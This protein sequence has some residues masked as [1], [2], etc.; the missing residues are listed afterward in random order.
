MYKGE[1]KLLL[2]KI[3]KIDNKIGFMAVV[4][5]KIDMLSKILIKFNCQPII[6]IDDIDRCTHD[7]AVQVLNAVKL[8]LSGTSKFYT[9]L[10]IDPRLVV[11]AIESSYKETIVKA[12]ITGY[13]FIDKIVQI[14]FVLPKQDIFSKRF[15]IKGIFE[16]I[17]ES[18]K[19]KKNNNS[20]TTIDIK[21]LTTK[22]NEEEKISD[23]EKENNIQFQKIMNNEIDEETT[24]LGNFTSDVKPKLPPGAKF[25][26]N[27]ST[28][29]NY[30]EDDEI[31][32]DQTNVE[33]KELSDDEDSS[34]DEEK[35]KIKENQNIDYNENSVVT[36]KDLIDIE[37]IKIF[38]DKYAKYL[39][40]NGRRLVRI[41]NVYILSRKIYNDLNQNIYKNPDVFD[42]II[43]CIIISE[44]WPYRTSFLLLFLDIKIASLYENEK[45]TF[46]TIKE[47]YDN[48]KKYLF[49]NKNL[50]N[51]SYNDSRD[52]L[53]NYMID[54]F[55]DFRS[56]EF[57]KIHRKYIFNLNPAITEEILREIHKEELKGFV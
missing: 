48:V 52:D 21:E 39:D 43:F 54:K 14:P 34:D 42:K 4:R 32:K 5:E 26:T 23:E 49:K 36:P 37:E 30:Y 47:A 18:L 55:A 10:A 35:N 1:S 8:L 9:F 6:F 12:G 50:I 24:I 51:L 41:I 2:E 46:I 45:L 33:N 22:T 13:D 53:F 3:N 56:F 38:C 31:S 25:I 16:G 27:G 57:H 19:N 7:K 29:F 44:Q 11:K 17:N 15:F 28:F 40:S 20:D